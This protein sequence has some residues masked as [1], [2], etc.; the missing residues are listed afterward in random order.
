MRAVLRR[1]GRPGVFWTNPQAHPPERERPEAPDRIRLRKGDAVI[2]A[3]DLGEAILGEQAHEALARRR[4]R[5]RRER[6]TLEQEVTREI[7]HGERIAVR[8]GPQA[9]LAFEVRSPYDVRRRGLG[10][11][12]REARVVRRP[13]AAARANAA[14]AFEQLA[15][16][17]ARRPGPP[18]LMLDEPIAQLHRP[19][20][21]MLAPQ[22]HDFGRHA[23]L[24]RMRGVVH[25]VR[26]IRERRL[27]ARAKPR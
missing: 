27:P 4:H 23:G 1:R 17:T 21:R 15:D 12:A 24:E 22:R 18:R 26:P 20:Q 11:A 3:Q 5:C 25:R 10:S 7:Q 6:G 8:P 16:R 2:G 9:K 13:L 19:V 14:R